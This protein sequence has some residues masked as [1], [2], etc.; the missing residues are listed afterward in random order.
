LLGAQAGSGGRHDLVGIYATHEL[1]EPA[2][3]ALTESNDGPRIAAAQCLGLAI[4]SQPAPL[5]LRAMAAEAIL[6]QDWL[7][8]T[9]EV[10]LS[11]EGQWEL[12]TGGCRIGRVRAD[13]GGGPEQAKGEASGCR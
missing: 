11:R 13:A 10:N 1:D 6:L 7:D 5:L 3:P 2:L 8:V 12:G 4:Q 9:D